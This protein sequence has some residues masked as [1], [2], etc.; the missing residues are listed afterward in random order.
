MPTRIKDALFGETIRRLDLLYLDG[1]TMKPRGSWDLNIGAGSYYGDGST[2]TGVITAESDP[3]AWLKATAQTGLTGDKT[4]SFNLTTTG[5]LSAGQVAFN[6]NAINPIYGINAMWTTSQANA[7]GI[8]SGI[9]NTYNGTLV[10]YTYGLSF[11][12]TWVPTIGG[13]HGGTNFLNYGGYGLTGITLNTAETKDY[14][15]NS[16]Y[17][18]LSTSQ[19]TSATSGGGVAQI[20]NNYNFY[21]DTP[22]LNTNSVITN[23]YAFYDEGQYIDATKTPNAWGLGIN[24]PNNYINGSL[25]IGSAV[26][27]TEVLDV[28]GNALISG[29]L[30]AG[31]ITGTSLIK[32]GGTSDQPLHADGSNTVMQKGS[33]A[34]SW[35]NAS[36]DT[37]TITFPVAFASAP[38]VVATLVYTPSYTPAAQG[39]YIVNWTIGAITTTTF[40]FKIA[41]GQGSA[42]SGTVQWIAWL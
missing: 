10:F 38:I 24:T 6:G 29:T 1:T 20:T 25:R 12:S 27:P 11:S 40:T 39:Y 16:N 23:G 32:S 22:T 3:L 17:G 36:I 31:A 13:S 42:G 35:T 18:Y 41:A 4:G 9:I 34:V 8:N 28:T 5:T 21:A 15:I 19:L 14:G 30:G 2:L 26:A 7:I 37:T 33:A